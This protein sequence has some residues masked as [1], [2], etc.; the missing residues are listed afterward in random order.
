MQGFCEKAYTG[1]GHPSKPTVSTVRVSRG[2]HH[3]DS[4]GPATTRYRPPGAAR[5]VRT[6]TGLDFYDHL[7]AR[8]EKQVAPEGDE[9]SSATDGGYGF[10]RRICGVF[11]RPSARTGERGSSRGGASLAGHCFQ[12][13]AVSGLRRHAALEARGQVEAVRVRDGCGNYQFNPEWGVLLDQLW[14]R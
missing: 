14:V 4:V 3:P 5:A 6:D 9:I 13:V 2:L 7:R 10:V 12:T 11:P 1:F 8:F